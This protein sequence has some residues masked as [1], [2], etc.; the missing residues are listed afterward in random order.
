MAGAFVWENDLDNIKRLAKENDCTVS[1]I[2]KAMIEDLDGMEKNAM[3]R[4]MKKAKDVKEE[5]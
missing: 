3:K 1:D 4:I 2:I 5:K